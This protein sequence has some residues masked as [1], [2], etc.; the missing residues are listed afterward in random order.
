MASYKMGWRFGA[1]WFVPEVRTIVTSLAIGTAIPAG[2]AKSLG[3]ARATNGVGIN[4]TMSDF[5]ALFVAAEQPVDIDALQSLAEGWAEV[6]ETAAPLSCTD[7]Y[8]GLV[9]HAHFQRRIHEVSTLGPESTGSHAL[10][11]IRL[12]GPR[13]NRG[14]CWTLLARLGEAVKGQL[15]GT[16][17][18]AMYQNSA[19]HILFPLGERS[20]SRLLGCKAVLEALGDG[21]L[22]PARMVL[23]PLQRH[24]PSAANTHP[25]TEHNTQGFEGPSRK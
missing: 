4:E 5:R 7:V 8:T 1:D 21:T 20:L 22:S 14:H 23:Y 10:A 25:V 3:A 24:E 11:I 2:R 6:A 12:P 19:V 16:G 18:M 9:T 13:H 17:S 15:H